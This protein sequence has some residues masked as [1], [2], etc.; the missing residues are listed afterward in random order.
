MAIGGILDPGHFSFAQALLPALAMGPHER[1]WVGNDAYL[2]D[3]RRGVR[4]A[5]GRCLAGRV[6]RRGERAVSRCASPVEPAGSRVQLDGGAIV[7]EALEDV[8]QRSNL[9]AASHR[10]SAAFAVGDPY[11]TPGLLG[12]LR[13]HLPV[14]TLKAVITLPHGW[15]PGSTAISD[16]RTIGPI[17]M[18]LVTFTS[19][20]PIDES[21]GPAVPLYVSQFS[22]GVSPVTGGLVLGFET[23]A[24]SCALRQRP[25]E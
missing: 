19:P 20:K 24:S 10:R 21:G 14:T 18:W 4:R 3:G 5:G 6:A 22:E 17:R 2:A 16:A 7:A 1:A 15:P 13:T 8:A 9:R 12:D 11:S 25:W 23:P